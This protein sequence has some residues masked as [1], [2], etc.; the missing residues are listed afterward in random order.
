MGSFKTCFCIVF[1]S[2]LHLPAIT[3]LVC[4]HLHPH[5]PFPTSSKKAISRKHVGIKLLERNELEVPHS[6]LTAGAAAQAILAKGS[7]SQKI[8][9]VK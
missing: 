4:S 3:F 5:P 8:K 2:N 1:I 9:Q 6:L 7:I